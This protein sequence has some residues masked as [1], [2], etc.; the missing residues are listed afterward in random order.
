MRNVLKVIS[1]LATVVLAGC[2]YP[3]YSYVRG[4][5]GGGY[6]SGQGYYGGGYYSGQGYYG[7]YGY[8]PAYPGYYD[9]GYGPSVG[10][11]IGYYGGD[12]GRG[13]YGHRDPDDHSWRDNGSHGGWRGNDSHG[14]DSHRDGTRHHH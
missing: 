11:G 9:G 12:Y 2:V 4:S 5:Y 1:V 14:R 3:D 10:I 13:Y 8:A 7:G 6:Y